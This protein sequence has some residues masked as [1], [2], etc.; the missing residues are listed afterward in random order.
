MDLK[1][2]GNENEVAQ[3]KVKCRGILNEQS[4]PKTNESPLN[5]RTFTKC[6]GTSAQFCSLYY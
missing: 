1:E 2:I 6:Q 4:S 5:N 3:D